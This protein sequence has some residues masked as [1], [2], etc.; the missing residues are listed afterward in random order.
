MLDSKSSKSLFTKLTVL[1]M[2]CFVV[3]T[4]S[5]QAI[6]SKENQQ[7]CSS[8]HLVRGEMGLF[9]PVRMVKVF[10]PNSNTD[11]VTFAF[12]E[13]GSLAS[14]ENTPYAMR[15]FDSKERPLKEQII[16]S[17]GIK[18]DVYS[19]YDEDEQ[20]FTTKTAAGVVFR[21]GKMDSKGRI[22]EVNNY[23]VNGHYVG[24]TIYEYDKVG[25][26][27][28]MSQYT[29]T[30]ILMSKS[31][32]SYDSNGYN[33]ERVFYKTT[34]MPPTE[35]QLDTK[36]IN[37]YDSQGRI[38]EKEIYFEKTNTI[39]KRFYTFQEFDSYGNWT[40]SLEKVPLLSG[41]ERLNIKT[42]Q[43]EYFE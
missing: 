15:T 25:L 37:R 10:L 26:V 21:V 11:Y 20:R 42:R 35:L 12:R 36:E 13:D 22:V 38:I 40:K 41:E 19:N 32:F 4:S 5:V 1:L 16:D 8:G 33:T 18:L 7:N 17:N 24:K 39:S 29:F 30:N 27:I 28:R 9:G 14:I 34:T 3:F 23:D 6:N 43:I 31:E 2:V